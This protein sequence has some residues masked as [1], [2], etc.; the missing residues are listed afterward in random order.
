[1]F[2]LYIS[3]TIPTFSKKPTFL[4]SYEVI[5]LLSSVWISGTTVME[6][7]ADLVNG[8]AG[9]LLTIV[10][11]QRNLLMSATQNQYLITADLP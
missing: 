11:S 4:L 5:I 9:D 8:I 2:R 7:L 10:V 6:L 3:N 1:M